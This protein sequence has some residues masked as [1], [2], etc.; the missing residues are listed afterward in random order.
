M[1]LYR[2]QTGFTLIELMIV[3]AII[4]ILA[5]L[6]IPA[7]QDYTVRARV[8]EGMSLA[9][10]AKLNVADVLN[11]GNPTSAAAGYAL[12]YSP[13]ATTRNVTSL[14]I[15]ATTGQVTITYAPAAGGGTIIMVPSVA[16][17]ALPNGAGAFTAPQ[18]SIAW[19]CST[20]TLAMRLRPAECRL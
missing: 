20:G 14:A 13:P 16:G 12:G 8:S 1:K 18:G 17:G 9:S 2:V 5:A 6:A 10:E 11:G 7:Y 15:A 4:G 3:V 19:T